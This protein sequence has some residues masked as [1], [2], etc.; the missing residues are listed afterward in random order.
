M[1]LQL[2]IEEI[3][4]NEFEDKSLKEFGRLSLPGILRSA[5]N[6]EMYLELEPIVS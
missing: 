3:V 1:A 6:D 5:M 2:N 4:P